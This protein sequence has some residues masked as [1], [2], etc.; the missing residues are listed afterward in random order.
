MRITSLR[1]PK[2]G[3]ATLI[4]AERLSLGHARCEKGVS[5]VTS[6]DLEQ[7]RDVL[8]LCATPAALRALHAGHGPSSLFALCARHLIDREKPREKALRSGCKRAR[9]ANGRC[10][11]SPLSRQAP[12]PTPRRFGLYSWGKVLSEAGHT[13]CANAEHD[14]K[15][16]EEVEPSFRRRSRMSYVALSTSPSSVRSASKTFAIGIQRSISLP[17]RASRGGYASSRFGAPADVT[18]AKCL[19][20]FARNSNASFRSFASSP[21]GATSSRCTRSSSTADSRAS[22][23]KAV[24]APQT[25]QCVFV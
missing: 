11:R 10:K 13:I 20:T 25:A 19:R 7:T 22:C 9:R 24:E 2:L 6:A 23:A 3:A 14:L 18:K 5:L 16:A 21:T 1:S 12:T 17:D 8:F 15:S 4:C